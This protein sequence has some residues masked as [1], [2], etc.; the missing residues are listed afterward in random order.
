MSPSGIGSHTKPN[1]GETNTWLTPPHVVAALGGF[2]LDPCAAVGWETA[3]RHIIWPEDGLSARW[4]GR[5]WLNPPYGDVTEHWLRRI[6]DHGNGT[7]LVFA[8]T[9]TAAWHRFIWPRAH[10]VLFFAGRLHFHYPDGTRAK[11]NAGGPSA[12]IAYSEADAAVL[13]SCGL[14]GRYVPLIGSWSVSQLDTVDG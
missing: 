1:N 8:R 13:A 11:A 4:E 5:V 6:A 9:E 7:A 12:L 3:R 2:D 14:A 10:A